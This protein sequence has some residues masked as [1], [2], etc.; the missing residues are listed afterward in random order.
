[1]DFI[2]QATTASGDNDFDNI[3]VSS[4]ENN[5]EKVQAYLASGI[6]INAKM[7][8]VFHLFML[9]QAMVT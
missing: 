4:T 5:L 1:M 2:A 7:S 6:N 3:W 9:L 8:M